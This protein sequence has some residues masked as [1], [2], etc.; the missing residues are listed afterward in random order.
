MMCTA[1]LQCWES[2][3]KLLD[4]ICEIAVQLSEHTVYR[5]DGY[6]C[7]CHGENIQIGNLIILVYVVRYI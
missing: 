2:V 6:C 7:M 5:Y 4:D 1:K 3:I